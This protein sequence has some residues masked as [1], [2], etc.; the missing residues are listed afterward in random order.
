M[1]AGGGSRLRASA[2]RCPP[3]V[4]VGIVPF[5]GARVDRLLAAVDALHVARQVP[6]VDLQRAAERAQRVGQAHELARLLHVRLPRH[7]RLPASR[8]RRSRRR[9]TS[10]ASRPARRRRRSTP[11]R[12]RS[13]P[14]WGR[15]PAA[16]ASMAPCRLP[17]RPPRAPPYP[18]DGPIRKH[19]TA[20]A[21]AGPGG[22]LAAVGSAPE[23]TAATIT[24]VV[25]DDHAVVRGGLRRLLDAEPDLRVVAEAGDV[26][27]TKATVAEHKP[28]ILLLD[29]HM[30][31]GGSLPAL[32]AI[33]D[34]S[35]TP[36]PDPDDAGR[37]RLRARGDAARRARVCAQGGRGGGPA[38][39]G[40]HRGGGR[41]LPAARAWR[42]AA[43]RRS[44]PS[45]RGSERCCGCSRSATRTPR[46]PIG[47]T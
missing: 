37:P 18:A 21:S 22:T 3:T 16:C 13:P 26:E 6:V 33:Q 42:A 8:W 46:R 7:A 24:I 32:R 9:S 30:P 5:A 15:R 17:P 45:P 41:H 19:L 34:A 11:P 4:P 10:A 2:T 43:Q 23:A 14:G 31:G 40:A 38:A 25:A 35:P 29:L 20:L 28:A 44:T 36:G 27:E 1:P 39:G 12:P 47:C